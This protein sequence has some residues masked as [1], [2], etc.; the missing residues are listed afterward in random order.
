MRIGDG[1]LD[2]DQAARDEASEE[3]G[4]ERLSLGLADVDRVNLPPPGLVNAVGDHQRL[5]DHAAAVTDLLDLGVEEQIRVA[6]LQRP[7]PERL[8]VLIQRLADAADLGLANAQAEALDELVDATRRD[9]ADISLLDD[10]EQRLLR[11]LPGLE[12]AR[13]VAAPPDLGDLQLDLPR[14]GVPAPRSIA[15]AMRRPI[16]GP[17]LAMLGSDQLG[18]LGLHQLC[19][20]GLDRLADHIG[21]LIE[22]H[23]PDDLLDRHPLSTGHAALLSSNREEVRRSSAP[24]GRN[25]VPSDLDLHH[26]TGRDP[27][28]PQMR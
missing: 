12:D 19:G 21:V 10:P 20:D 13:E 9:P 16:I 7:G 3:L 11:A 14:P 6:A 5:V 4:P 22:Q 27:S 1:E 24:R 18:D 25:H 23:L 15:V 28:A 8:D 26:A 2:A 17:A